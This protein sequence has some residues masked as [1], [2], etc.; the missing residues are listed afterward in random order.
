MRRPTISRTTPALRV[1]LKINDTMTMTRS[2]IGRNVLKCPMPITKNLTIFSRTNRERME[3]E[4]H[5][6]TSRI[7]ESGVIAEIDIS[8]ITINASN[9]TNIRIAI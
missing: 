5:F 4:I 2:N 6:V 7:G 8:V 3:N 1:I 9:I